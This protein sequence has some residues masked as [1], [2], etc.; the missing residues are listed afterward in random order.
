MRT[1]NSGSGGG[2]EKK[3]LFR[4]NSKAEWIGHGDWLYPNAPESQ[5]CFLLQPMSPSGYAP[6]S[7]LPL[8]IISST[9]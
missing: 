4:E 9:L 2:M 3:T 5:L 1:L 7:L 8:H 6:S